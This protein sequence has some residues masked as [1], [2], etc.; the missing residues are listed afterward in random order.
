VLKKNPPVTEVST[1]SKMQEGILLLLKYVSI[2]KRQRRAED[3]LKFNIIAE[4]IAQVPGKQ[5]AL[6]TSTCSAQKNQ[7]HKVSH[8][9]VLMKKYC[10]SSQFS[11]YVLEIAEADL[12]LCKNTRVP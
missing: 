7:Y 10:Q 11:K 5:E 9:L 8:H 2:I 1:T 4:N 3:I 12:V 6:T